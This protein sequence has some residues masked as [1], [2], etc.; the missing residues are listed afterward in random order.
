LEEEEIPVGVPE[1]DVVEDIGDENVN[2][3]LE[4]D[5]PGLGNEEEEEE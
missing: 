4:L 1:V 3:E 5:A 2:E